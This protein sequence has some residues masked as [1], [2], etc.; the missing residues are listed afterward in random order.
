MDFRI[1]SLLGA[2]QSRVNYFKH[3][4]LAA[5]QMMADDCNEATGTNWEVVQHG[6]CPSYY[7][8]KSEDIGLYYDYPLIDAIGPH[9]DDSLRLTVPLRD[10]ITGEETLLYLNFSD[11]ENYGT[12]VSI[13]GYDATY[14]YNYLISD[15]VIDNSFGKKYVGKAILNPRIPNVFEYKPAKGGTPKEVWADVKIMIAEA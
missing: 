6:H 4:I 11:Q 5:S 2:V 12:T 15:R 1:S 9:D 7:A 3:A 10:K 14:C 8:G 13:Y